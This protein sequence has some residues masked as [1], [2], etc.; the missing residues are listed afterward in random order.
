MDDQSRKQAWLKTGR[1]VQVVAFALVLGMWIVDSRGGW[2]GWVGIILLSAVM[3]SSLW[4][5]I[6]DFWQPKP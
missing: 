4:Q 2:V 6:R 3:I 5:L 1:L